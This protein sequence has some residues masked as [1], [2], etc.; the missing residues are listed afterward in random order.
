M[1]SK[2]TPRVARRRTR[3]QAHGVVL[4]VVLVVIVI[5]S[6]T[7]YTFA[8]L[9][10]THR[11][12]VDLSGRQLQTRALVDS[13]M[14][15]LQLYFQKDAAT[16][17]ELGGHFNNQSYFMAINVRQA[18]T[19]R[20]RGSFTVLA[21]NIDQ[22]GQ[23]AGVRYGV[24]DL[25][26]RLN[27]NSL[28]V[29][30]TV[31]PGGGRTLLMALPNMTEEI[32]DA[33]L[34]WIDADDEP[35]EFG[36]ESADYASL[37]PPYA[38]RNGPLE[39]VE[40]LLLVRGVTPQLL[41]GI[42]TNRNGLLDASEQMSGGAGSTGT[43]SSDSGAGMDR[44]WIGYIT[45][46]S[47]EKNVNQLGQPR[48]NL[49]QESLQE[50]YHQL[51]AVF[52]EEWAVFIVAYRQNGPANAAD[53]GESGAGKQL[54]FEQPAKQ[55]LTQVLDLIGKKTQVQFQGENRPTTLKAPFPQDLVAQAVYLPL[56]MDNCTVVAS[57]S[58]PGRININQAPRAILMGIPGM[59][60]QRVDQ[61]L[62]QRADLAGKEDEDPNFKHETWLL[63]K[64]LVSLDEMRTLMPF[65]TAGGNVFQ[66]QVVGYFEDGSAASRAEVVVDATGTK[67][68]VVFWRDISH[69]G[70]GYPLELLGASS[71]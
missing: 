5:L 27:L 61:I 44:G 11:K 39:T 33:I 60:E 12:S 59:T 42:D 66:A 49:N 65:V 57:P 8:N 43:T 54:N 24:E 10:L 62:E 70:C 25:S 21:P 26:T 13:G 37:Q 3:T 51:T 55:T 29:A 38:P 1:R 22:E 23:L 36:A 48:I 64:G 2:T 71:L 67:P 56:L 46:Y 35:R 6:L 58:I 17:K 31:M 19:A 28:V 68:R 32:A 34:D 41:F 69:L 16:Q 4:V 15:T 52:S 53:E 9:M 45:I 63:A 7:A 30:E 47:Q 40:E 50:L 20:D 14:A 18:G